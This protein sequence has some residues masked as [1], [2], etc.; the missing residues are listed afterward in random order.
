MQSLKTSSRPAAAPEGAGAEARRRAAASASASPPFLHTLSVLLF[1][2]LLM[3]LAAGLYRGRYFDRLAGYVA[4][5]L[6]AYFHNAGIHVQKIVV[7]GQVNLADADILAALGIAT[8][9]SLFGFDAQEAQQRLMRL[10]LVKSARVMRMLPSTLLVEIE[11]RAPFAR[12]QRGDRTDLIDRDGVVLSG[13]AKTDGNAYPL[14]AGEGAGAVAEQLIRLMTVHE[15]L[16]EAV[17]MA[18]FVAGERWDLVARSGAVVR[19]PAN[20][21]ALALARFVRLPDWAQLLAEAGTVVDMRLPDRAFVRRDRPPVA[22][23]ASAG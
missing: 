2:A 3:L 1:V 11:E 16:A 23:A 4:P 12:W 19:L 13:A 10:Q 5:R 18:R 14:V 20:E 9:Q 21:V 17:A 8:G 6:E 15:R 22:T 7:K